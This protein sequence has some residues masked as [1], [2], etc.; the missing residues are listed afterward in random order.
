MARRAE[1]ISKRSVHGV[2]RQVSY[3]APEVLLAEPES[4]RLGA[5]FVVMTRVPGRTLA[6]TAF[7]GLA[8]RTF[9]TGFLRFMATT[10]AEAQA[11][12]HALEASPFGD[13]LRREWPRLQRCSTFDRA[14]LTVSKSTRRERG[15]DPNAFWPPSTQRASGRGPAS[16]PCDSVHRGFQQNV[17]CRRGERG[18]GPSWTGGL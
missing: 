9:R 8:L 4:S 18:R 15:R 17:R 12:L 3:P 1:R 5:E 14:S 13:K 2:L 11:K 16:A 6:E 7:S 10:L